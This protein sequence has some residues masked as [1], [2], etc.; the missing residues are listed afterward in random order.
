MNN[1]EPEKNLLDQIVDNSVNRFRNT[2]RGLD[3]HIYIGLQAILD[4]VDSLGKANDLL[5]VIKNQTTIKEEDWAEGRRIFDGWDFEPEVVDMLC[6][7]SK[8]IQTR[9]P[10]LAEEEQ[11]RL[12]GAGYIYKE[13]NR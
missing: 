5:N 2:P 12:E 6:L 3:G 11:H 7:V 8:E 4:T 9:Y 1:K 10:E 13:R